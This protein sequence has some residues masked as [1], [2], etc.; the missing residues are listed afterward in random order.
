[1]VR[2]WLIRSLALTLLTLCVVVCVGSYWRWT[3]IRRVGDNKILRE[4]RNTD[5]VDLECGRIG[6]SHLYPPSTPF[7]WWE[8][9]Y[10][11]YISNPWSGW[12]STAIFHGIGFAFGQ[13]GLGWFVTIPL[14][15][16][17]L[18]SA[19]LLSVVWRKTKPKVMGFPIEPTA[20]TSPST[21]H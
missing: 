18:L 14:Y 9:E 10:G 8:F 3:G 12:D 6:Y 17:T 20:I 4:I 15:F 19:L 11:S 1:M 5:I 2:C 21:G 7:H 16:P 13:N